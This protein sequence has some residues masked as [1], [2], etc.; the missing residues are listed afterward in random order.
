M[1]T[2]VKPDLNSYMLLV[3]LQIRLREC[4]HLRF[5][6]TVV[7]RPSLHMSQRG[8]NLRL[9]QLHPLRPSHADQ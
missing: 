5:H 9:S 1:G 7:V 8:S 6:G 4:T 2:I 3:N